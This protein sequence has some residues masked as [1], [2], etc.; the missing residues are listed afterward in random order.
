MRP[1]VRKFYEEQQDLLEKLQAKNEE[2]VQKLEG[3]VEECEG[4][5][6]NL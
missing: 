1:E 6:Q 5:Q 3:K 2:L 4:L